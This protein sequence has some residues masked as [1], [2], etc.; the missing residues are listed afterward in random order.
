[1]RRAV[2]L[3]LAR[4]G[5]REVKREDVQLAAQTGGGTWN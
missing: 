4:E 1:M 2:Y 5:S 3:G